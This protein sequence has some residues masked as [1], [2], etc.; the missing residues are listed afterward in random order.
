MATA[1]KDNSVT[2]P[3][4]RDEWSGA[5]QAWVPVSSAYLNLGAWIPGGLGEQKVLN[6]SKTPGVKMTYDGSNLWCDYKG[7]KFCVPKANIR[8]IT[9]A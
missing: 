7:N 1:K 5:P 2:I 9:V 8:S 3:A 4:K 6:E